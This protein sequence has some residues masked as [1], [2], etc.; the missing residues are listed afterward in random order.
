MRIFWL[1]NHPAPYKIEFF[2]R[3]GTTNELTVYFE[4]RSESGRNKTFYG[5]KVERFEAHFG[6]PLPLGG[7]NS[8]SREPIEFLKRHEDYDL[9]VLNGW[10]TITERLC[11]SYCKKHKIPYVFYI[12]GGI[13]REHENNFAYVFKRHYISGATFCMAPDET[14]KQYLIHYGADPKKIYLYPYGSVAE[15]DLFTQ[16]YGASGIQK[17]R[18]KVGIVEEKAFVSAGF[19]IQRKG[20]DRLIAAWAH[21]PK[22]AGLYLIGEGRRGRKLKRQAKALHLDNVHFIPFMDHGKLFRFYKACDAFLFPTYEDI[23][24]HVVTEA[25]S[26]GLPVFSSDKANAAKRLIVQN[27]NGAIVDFDNPEEVQIVLNREIAPEMKSAAIDTARH[28]TYEESAKAHDELF[29]MMV[30]AIQ[31]ENR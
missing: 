1:F 3:L 11:I 31:G 18:K 8:F 24:G 13:A 28:Y 20:F 15:A 25:M 21:M 12:N 7:V 19:F 5:R 29:S 27:V 30:Q 9:I 17:I 2:N 4:R 14:S 23:Y 6:K 16:A 22:N 10:R 26:Q